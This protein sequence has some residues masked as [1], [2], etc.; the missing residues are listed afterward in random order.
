[1]I[2]SK[3]TEYIT[4]RS[5][6]VGTWRV[7]IVQETKR[8]EESIIGRVGSKEVWTRWQRVE[9]GKWGGGWHRWGW[10]RMQ[11][12]QV[13]GLPARQGV[14]LYPEKSERPWRLLKRMSYKWSFYLPGW[15]PSLPS[16]SFQNGYP[17]HS[18][19]SLPKCC[20]GFF[21]LYCGNIL[22]LIRKY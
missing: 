9:H 18:S 8:L 14:A 10:N 15:Q 13:Q 21:L 22:T 2:E 16:L 3:R 6:L 7:N 1:M 12:Q 19:S 5:N 4:G 17:F 20:L 11:G